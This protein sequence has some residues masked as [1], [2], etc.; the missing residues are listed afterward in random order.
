MS[1]SSTST[2]RV[3]TKKAAPKTDAV[4]S[5]EREQARQ[6]RKTKEDEL[7]EG[8]EDTFPASDPVS[9]TGTTTAGDAGKPRK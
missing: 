1:A 8:L 3:A 6:A 4:R 7:R 9:V 2:S 5:L